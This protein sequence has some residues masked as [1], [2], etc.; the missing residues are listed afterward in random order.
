MSL[1][2]EDSSK[3]NYKAKVSW[4]RE[5]IAELSQ[6]FVNPSVSTSMKSP[7]SYLDNLADLSKKA[8]KLS[9]RIDE[10]S[11]NLKIPVDKAKDQ[12]VYDALMKIDPSSGG[13]SVSYPLYKNLLEKLNAGVNNVNVTDIIAKSSN[14]TQSNSKLIQSSMYAGYAAH[15]GLSS[16]ADYDENI[17][18]WDVEDYASRQII[19]FADNFLSNFYQE[20]YEPW[21]FKQDVVFEQNQIYGFQNLWSAY[22]NAAVADVKNIGVAVKDMVSL[23]P[24]PGIANVTDRYLD[25]TNKFLNDVNFLF[26]NTWTADIICCFVKFSVKLDEKT[27]RGLQTLL[28]FLRFS[29]NLDF[30]DLLNAFKDVLNNIMRYLI[31]NQLMGFMEQ[32]I[33]RIVDPIER[34]IHNQDSNWN[35]VFECLP[36]KQL[37]D[38]YITEAIDSAE[39]YIFDLLNEW[40]K[41]LEFRKIGHDA[42]IFQANENKWLNRAINLLDMVIRAMELAATCSVNDT[43]QSDEANKVLDQISNPNIYVYP[44]EENPNIYNS[45]I[46]P[47]QQKAIEDSKAAGDSAAAAGI[48]NQSMEQDTI[49]ISKRLDDCRKNIGVSDLPAP[50]VWLEQFIQQY[51]GR[52]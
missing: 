15:Y 47:E 49:T 12:S 44:T 51:Q 29:L 21:L 36:I 19:N 31:M 7:E 9:N 32:M 2:R 22:S 3:I 13:E 43:P 26:N 52:V 16:S 24:D 42:K 30:N 5:R 17:L 35:K 20:E 25:Y 4:Y 27:L 1:S 38:Q 45:F 40:Y 14:D 11:V 33:Q 18:Q 23:R 50:I 41:Y 37:I 46:T 6:G 48:I 34:W 8:D 10:A 28:N 39:K